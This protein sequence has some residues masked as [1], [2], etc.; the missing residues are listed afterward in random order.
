MANAWYS[1]NPCDTVTLH[2]YAMMVDEKPK[3][4]VVVTD[5]KTIASVLAL[6]DALPTT[7]DK[8]K[9][10]SD[11]TELLQMELSGGGKT[12]MV[13]FYDG[14]LKTPATTIMNRS[15]PEQIQLYKL[16]LSLLK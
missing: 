1:C 4:T 13:E 8:Y 6:L 11:E 14:Q 12:S 7:G 10:F 5:M 9:S 15:N 3:K 2:Q 16:A